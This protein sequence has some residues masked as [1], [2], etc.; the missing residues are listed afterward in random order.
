M[1][2]IHSSHWQKKS[3]RVRSLSVV[4]FVILLLP[5]CQ[6]KAGPP[7]QR[8]PVNVHLGE[9]KSQKVPLYI[10]EIGACVALQSVSIIPQVSGAITKIA[11]QDGAQVKPGDLLFTIDPRTYQAVLDKALATIQSNRATLEF[12]R[13]QLT[14]SESLVKGNFI[15][16]QDIDNLKTQVATLEATVKQNE[17]EVTSAQIN[18]EYCT[19]TSPIEGKTGVRQVDVGDVVTG[20]APTS[21]LSIQRL[22]P[23]YV[24]FIVTENDLPRVKDYFTK[25]SLNVQVYLPERPKDI[26][27][28]EMFFLDNTVQVGTGTVKLRALMQNKDHYFWPGQFVKVRLI[29]TE[30]PDATVVP[31]SAIQIG[32]S[33][34]FVYVAKEDKTVELRNVT[35]GQRLEN[36]IVIEKGVV[37]AEKIVL[38]GQLML[39]P[40]VTINAVDDQPTDPSAPAPGVPPSEPDDKENE[41]ASPAKE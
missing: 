12:S 28:G 20:Y 2:P 6:K 1:N 25:G 39:A 31:Y 36:D 41:K 33:G 30:I 19:I 22:D 27:T 3:G 11:F 34:P 35:L 4:L 21:L 29:L 26:R 16:S 40:G 7:P 13:S 38:D 37:P 15:S 32:H 24:D 5:A 18:L 14:R 9:A 10:D 8:P 23:L 17:A